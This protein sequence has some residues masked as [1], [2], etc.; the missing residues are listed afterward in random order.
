MSGALR[1]RLTGDT[2]G[3]A[4]GTRMRALTYDMLADGV[5]VGVCE[6]R[7]ERTWAAEW[8]G[9]VSYTVFPPWRGR[10]Y[11][12]VALGLLARAAGAMGAESLT[13][14]CRPENAASRRTLERAGAV[15]EGVREVPLAHPLRR[16]GV[17]H[18]AV[19]RIAIKEG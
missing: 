8:T 16:S 5:R 9:Q 15:L 14:T 3:S 1:L 17:T 19:Y 18:V 6:L 11:A 7:P 2:P 10:H 13:V 12:A 4:D